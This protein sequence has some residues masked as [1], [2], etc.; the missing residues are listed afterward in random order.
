MSL[1]TKANG[2]DYA[3]LVEIC[4][5]TSVHTPASLPF[6]YFFRLCPTL[7][8]SNISIP[9]NSACS[10]NNQINLLATKYQETEVKLAIQAVVVHIFC[11]LLI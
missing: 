4:L 6:E 7:F 11:L 2:F 10:Q 3:E 1:L 5:A 9:H 8:K